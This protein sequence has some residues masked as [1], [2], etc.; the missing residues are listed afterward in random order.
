VVELIR[1]ASR[2]RLARRGL[3]RPFERLW[4]LLTGRKRSS[5]SAG[6]LEAYE[7]GRDDAPGW[8]AVF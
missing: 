6:L 5:A 2:F 3:R 7:S 4:A 8:G 1:R